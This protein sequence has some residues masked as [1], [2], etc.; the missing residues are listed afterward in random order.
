MV[1]SSN[2]S[3]NHAEEEMHPLVQNFSPA[4]TIFKNLDVFMVSTIL[5]VWLVCVSPQH[6]KRLWRPAIVVGASNDILLKMQ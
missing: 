5:K 2:E 6:E 4:Q 3:L 1:D